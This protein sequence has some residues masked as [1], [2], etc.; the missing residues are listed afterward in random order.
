MLHELKER[1]AAGQR[2]RVALVGAGFTGLGIARQVTRTPGMDLAS[3]TD[4]DL[5]A[6]TKAAQACGKPYATVGPDDPLPGEESLL[7]TQDPLF[8]FER[9]SEI[10]ID[11]VVEATGSLGFGARVSLAAI[12]NGLH[13]VLLNAEVDLTLGSLLSRAAHQRGVVYTSDAGDQHGVLMRMME[14]IQLWDFRIIMA[15]NIK[16]FHNLYATPE[17]LVHEARIRNLNPIQC[18]AFTDGTKLGFEMALV[19][20]GTGLR[21]WVPGMEGP[22]A[23][24]VQEV[25]DLFDFTRYGDQ[26]VVDYILGAEPGG[27]VFVVGYCDDEIQQGYLKYLKMGDGP[28]YLFYRPYHLVPVETPRAVAAAALYGRPILEPKQGRVSDVYAYA[29][30]DIQAGETI[31]RGI[32]GPHFYG[33]I[34]DCGRASRQGGVPIALLASEDGKEARIKRTLRRDRPLSYDDVDLPQTNLL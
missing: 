25:L 6:A 31:D 11:V 12:D 23:K 18:C 15:G 21:T 5:Q 1:E 26:G 27:G 13:L 16:G 3:I 10:G 34:D 17:S 4:R 14:E 22:Q 9:S 32:G 2:I 7:V 24:H 19:S 8:L 28:Y 30:R 29:K 33:M 20:N